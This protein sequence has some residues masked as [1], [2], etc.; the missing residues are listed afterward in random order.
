MYGDN[1]TFE[2]KRKGA[3]HR[4]TYTMTGEDLD[5]FTDNEKKIRQLLPDEP[6]TASKALSIMMKYA[7]AHLLTN[8][9]LQ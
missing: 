6:M 8:E 1:H 5:I 7:A 2:R 4:R 9:E 3:I